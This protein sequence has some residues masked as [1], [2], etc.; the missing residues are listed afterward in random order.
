MYGAFI[1]LFQ[2]SVLCLFCNMAS[3]LRPD[4]GSREEEEYRYLVYLFCNLYSTLNF[5]KLLILLTILLELLTFEKIFT[6]N[7]FP[8]LNFSHF[9]SASRLEAA[10]NK[11]KLSDC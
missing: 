4:I 10:K 2:E 5:L 1:R 3:V 9:C 6:R 8:N 7:L 11:E